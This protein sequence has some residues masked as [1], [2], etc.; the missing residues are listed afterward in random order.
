MA[1]MAYAER[2]LKKAGLEPCWLGDNGGEKS[3]LQARCGNMMIDVHGS[4]GKVA[5]IRV[6]LA[7]GVDDLASAYFMG[8]DMSDIGEAIR[9]AKEWLPG[10]RRDG[11]D[12]G[13]P[14]DQWR[15]MNVAEKAQAIAEAYMADKTQYSILE[16]RARVNLEAYRVLEYIA[17]HTDDELNAG[18]FKDWLDEW[19]Y[20]I[21][22][23]RRREEGEF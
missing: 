23:R 10:S 21:R 3:L 1:S 16:P 5:N 2:E 17:Q 9:W 6:R 4:N 14:Q 18:T 11:D 12:G 13:M 22:K 20:I 7:D 8:R 15:A 19:G